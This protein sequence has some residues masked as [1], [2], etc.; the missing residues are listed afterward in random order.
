V[1]PYGI[2][3]V[4]GFGGILHTG[5]L[6]AVIIFS[7]VPIVRNTA[8]LFKTLALNVKIALLPFAAGPVFVE[9]ARE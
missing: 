8:E 6:F 5:D 3:S 7:K 2:R 1:I 4:L 9:P